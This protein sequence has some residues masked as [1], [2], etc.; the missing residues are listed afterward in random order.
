MTDIASA[1]SIDE[2]DDEFDLDIRID[3]IGPA[4]PKRIHLASFAGSCT[5]C[6]G[7][8]IECSVTAY[9]TDLP[10]APPPTGTCHCSDFSACYCTGAACN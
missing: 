2:I 10:C 8:G 3:D 7:G 6:C 1:P 9:C 5:M 4:D